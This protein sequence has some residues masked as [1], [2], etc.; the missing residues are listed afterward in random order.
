MPVNAL[1]PDDWTLLANAVS[2]TLQ[3]SFWTLLVSLPL[4]T[5]FGVIR[6][7]EL[8]GVSKAVAALVDFIRAV[9]LVFYVVAI[10]LVVPASPLAQAVLALS[11]HTAATLCEII[12]GG[13]Q[14]IDH[15]QL[16][17]ARILGL[18]LK[19]RLLHVALP[20]AIRR[21]LPALVSQASVVVKD[22]TL[23]SIGVIELTKAVQ[24]LNMR[25]LN[26][27]VEFM[28]MVA[29]FYFVVCQ[30]LTMIGA[31]LERRWALAGQAA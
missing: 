25:H 20:Q 23:V 10:F 5:A 30:V 15:K 28:L 26:L 2:T 21:M 6:Y 4:G 3:I 1:T 24:I 17:M 22:T 29:V 16:Q 19:D 11:T 12:R 18:S 14:S 7:L 27:S 13:L 31:W 8:P 9:P